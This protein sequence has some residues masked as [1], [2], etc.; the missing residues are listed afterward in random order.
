MK[1]TGMMIRHAALFLFSGLL[2]V[3]CYNENSSFGES[4]VTSSFRS[5]RTDTSTITV[6]SVLIDSVETSGKGVALAG[7]YGHPLWGTFIATP[8]VAFQRPSYSTDTEESVRMDS[9]VLMLKHNRYFLGDTTLPQ[10]FTVHRLSEKIILN[11]NGYLYNRSTVAYDPEPI[12]E[13]TYRPR[14]HSEEFYEVRLSDELGKDLLSKFHSYDLAV[15]SDRFENYFKGIAIVPDGQTGRSVTG[16]SVGDTA[17]AICLRYTLLDDQANEQELLFKPNTSTQF[18]NIRHDRT[19]TAMAGYAEQ[20]V[21]IPSAALQGKGVLM[22]GAGWYVR[23]GFPHLNNFRSMGEY[24]DIDEAYLKIHPDRGTYDS[25][26]ALPDSIY[27]YIVDENNVVTDAVTDYLGEQVQSGTLVKDDTFYENTYYFFDISDF[28]R[29]ELGA[30]GQYKHSLQLVFGSDDYTNT[31][32][33][34]TIRD[35][36]GELP[37]TLIV[38]FKVYESY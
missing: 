23:L 30:S 33:N 34:L 14:P 37:I 27:L 15:S 32:K 16:F 18:N 36:S 2:S 19:G 35:Q 6:T 10:R 11:D 7:Q 4:L 17:L 13:F 21:E 25:F 3:S 24:V 8:Y 26:N 1:D 22:G 20:K 12:G 9:L 29:E 38:T 31:C 28:I 5:V